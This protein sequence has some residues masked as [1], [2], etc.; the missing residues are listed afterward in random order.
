MVRG[1]LPLVASGGVLSGSDVVQRIMRGASAVEIYTAF[2]Y[3]GVGGSREAAAGDDCGVTV[4]RVFL[5]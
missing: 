3:Y 2:V 1:E 5:R 4:V